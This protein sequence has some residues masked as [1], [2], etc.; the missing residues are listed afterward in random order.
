MLRVRCPC[1][2]CRRASEQSRAATESFDQTAEQRGEQTADEVSEGSQLQLHG[3]SAHSSRRRKRQ[4][5]RVSA[6]ALHCYLVMAV[7]RSS[8]SFSALLYTWQ[9]APAVH[10][11][12]SAITHWHQFIKTA[13]QPV[14]LS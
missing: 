8:S 10:H 1:V 13:R 2:A 12:H 6:H 4:R 14:S 7:A 5:K 9:H 3:W 11:L